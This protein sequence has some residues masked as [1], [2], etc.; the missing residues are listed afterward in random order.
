MCLDD[1]FP[2]YKQKL[3]WS[4]GASAMHHILDYYGME[5]SEFSLIKLAGTNKKNGTPV[6]GITKIANAYNLDFI[7][8]EELSL[9]ELILNIRRNNPVILAIQALSNY[10]VHDWSNEWNS[11]H[12]VVATGYDPHYRCV[13]Y[14]DPGLGRRMSI[15]Y[16]KLHKRWHDKDDNKVYD[17]LGIIFRGIKDDKI[18]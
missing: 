9:N 12:Y 16:T 13:R 6:D 10:K 8:K 11:G 4:C 2:R 7:V 18:L 17:H 1:D 15:N 14:Q 3:E 5:V